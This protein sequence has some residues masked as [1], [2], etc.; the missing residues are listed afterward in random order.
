M[1]IKFNGEF[2]KIILNEQQEKAVKTDSKKVFCLASAGSGKTRV[3][4][5]RIA[6]LIENKNVSPYDIQAQTFTRKAAQEMVKRLEKRIGILAHK[7]TVGTQHAVALNFI[8]K[9]GDLIGLRPEK[10]TVYNQFESDYLLKDTAIELGFHSGYA[11]TGVDAGN[12]NK[13]MMMYSEFETMA[14]CE[15]VE[16]EKEIEII[17]AFQMR[18]KENNALT[19]DSILSTFLKLLPEIKDYLNFKHVFVDE[20]QDNS[21]IQWDITNE[22]CKLSGAALFAVGDD[23]QAIYQFR[24]A[25]PEYIIKNQK[26]FDIFKLQKNY[27]S[28]GAIVNAANRLIKHNKNRLDLEMIPVKDETP[29]AIGHLGDIDSG[30]ICANVKEYMKHF[31]ENIAVLANRHFLLEKLSMLLDQAGIQH[32]YLGKKTKLARSEEFVRFHAFLKLIVNPYD[33]FAF[34]LIKDILNIDMEQ[35]GE[36][37]VMASEQG[38]SHFQTWSDYRYNGDDDFDLWLYPDSRNDFHEIIDKMKDIKFD[39][40]TEP[41]FDFVYTWIIDNPDKGID[42]YL[43]WLTTYDIQ[44]EIKKEPE[45]LQLMTIHASKGLEWPTVIIAGLNETIFPDKRSI[46]KDPDVCEERNLAYVAMTRAENQLIL[47]SRH[48]KS[49][50]FEVK[51]PV[52]RFVGEALNKEG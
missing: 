35:Y 45:K 47:T 36:I 11:W 22:I 30:S 28:D 27:R 46:K 21:K 32:E 39:F 4:I 29:Q 38:K 17:E 23:S 41:I 18:C 24:G 19:Y 43:S 10:I 9:F 1:S 49:D 40:E 3:L 15:R 20:C 14:F 52:S 44:D 51:N 13:T 48:L 7:I 31:D 16:F 12:L 37:R 33:N 6:D 2:M 26:D 42:D 25:T 34:L 5:E 8:Q 50:L